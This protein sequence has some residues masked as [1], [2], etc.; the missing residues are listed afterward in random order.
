MS[1]NGWRLLLDAG[2]A[3]EAEAAARQAL[4]IDVND[5]EVRQI[6]T[7]SLR[8]QNKTSEIEPLRKLLEK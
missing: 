7:T 4:E 5:A 2:K 1:A 3:P 8:D 6:L